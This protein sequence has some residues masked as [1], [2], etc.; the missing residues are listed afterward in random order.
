MR[1][2]YS[3]RLLAALLVCVITTSVCFAQSAKTI[4]A[5]PPAVVATGKPLR[6]P[7]TTILPNILPPMQPQSAQAVY[8]HGDPSAEEQYLLELINRGRANPAAE[9]DRLSTTTDVNVSGSYDYFK[10]PTRAQVKS[11]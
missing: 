3:I 4:H 2:N 5:A 9:G 7:P 11:D 1:S 8:S 10:T 6:T